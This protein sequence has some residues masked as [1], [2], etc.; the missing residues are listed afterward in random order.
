MKIVFLTRSLQTGGAER[1]LA[2]L[3]RGLALAE[4]DV[5]V[6]SMYPVPA[7]PP[8]LAASGVR[9]HSLEKRSRW[10]LAGFLARLLAAVRREQPEVLLSYLV[11]PNLLA[12][13]LG[14]L[15]RPARIVWAVRAAD[16]DLT[17][18]DRFARWTFRL[19]AHASALADMV[20]F[21]S[22][23]GL[24][25]HRSQ[26]YHAPRME[27]VA[28]GI[29]TRAWFPAPE[30]R[31][32]VRRAWGLEDSNP[33]IGL[34][35]RLD[36]IKD[37]PVFLEAAALVA[38]ERPEARFV[39][40]G[41]GARDYS[42][43]LRA[44]AARLGL[45]ARLLWAG[46]RRDMRAVYSALDLLV[47]SSISEGFPNTPAEAMACGVPC[48]VTDVGDSARLVGPHG[49]VVPPR[50]PQALS[51]ALLATLRAPRPEPAALVAW[52][53]QNFSVE[54]MVTATARLLESVVAG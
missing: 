24:A 53:E 25:Y 10:D 13:G 51:A 1:Q 49:T 47:S 27:V 30:E 6:L 22:E 39:V 38:A 43:S 36:P 37:H 17:L 45:D 23:A 50:N 20:I 52:I 19:S 31:L 29:D 46:E 15:V 9:L 33:L 3:A 2:V 16:M 4:H 40:V 7:P 44:R 8:E 54:R 48:V 14:P 35:A 28:N 18:Y 26:G 5:T 41:G 32:A 21:N 42:A 34:V 12:A 11:V